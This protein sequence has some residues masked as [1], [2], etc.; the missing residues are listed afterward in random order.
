MIQT[1]KSLSELN[2]LISKNDAVM[3]YFSLDTCGVC[4]VLQ[5]KIEAMMAHSFPKM[6]QLEVK[7][8]ESPDIIGQYS[9]FTAPVL[10]IFFQGK[11]FLRKAQSFGV[12]EVADIIQRPYSLMFA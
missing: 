12:N 5:P 4:H 11:E 9:I 2:E 6:K 3:V 1:V 8:K 10:L 7:M